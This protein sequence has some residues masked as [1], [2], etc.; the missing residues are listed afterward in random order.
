MDQFKGP[1][2]SPARLVHH[3]V[4][5]ADLAYAACS[6]MGDQM[7]PPMHDPS[8]ILYIYIFNLPLHGLPSPQWVSSNLH[9]LINWHRSKVPLEVMVQV[10]RG[11][12][13]SES[14]AVIEILLPPS[15]ICLWAS[16]LL[17]LPD[18]PLPMTHQQQT[19]WE[20]VHGTVVPCY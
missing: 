12:S 17:I 3:Q 9:L 8:I 18:L 19:G 11:N 10:G 4:H 14:T 20:E 5:V 1:I 6:C 13:I 16:L 2:L 7:D 15:S